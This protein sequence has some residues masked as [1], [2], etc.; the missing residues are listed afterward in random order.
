VKGTR[1]ASCSDS[2]ANATELQGANAPGAFATV[3]RMKKKLPPAEI[4][5]RRDYVRRVIKECFGGNQAALGRRLGNADGSFIGQMLRDGRTVSETT[6]RA[7]TELPEVK[8]AGIPTP[9]LGVLAHVLSHPAFEDQ[10]LTTEQIMGPGELPKRFVFVLPDD[11]LGSDYKAGTH[12]VFE[13]CT[14]ASQLKIGAGMLLKH[15]GELHVRRKA[16]GD[17]PGKWVGK[18]APGRQHLFRDIDSDSG[19]E[20]VGWWRGVINRG[21]ED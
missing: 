13:Y 14:D 5:A 15:N 3:S 10:L 9:N 11:A 1:R 19:A 20:L 18:A 17:G 2:E 6:I 8:N 21:L 12:V 7:I 16:Q 4:A